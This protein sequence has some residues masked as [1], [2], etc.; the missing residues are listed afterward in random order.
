M[1][2]RILSVVLGLFIVVSILTSCSINDHS[3]IKPTK[4]EQTFA[5]DTLISQD[6]SLGN[7]SDGT[8]RVGFIG[9]S[10]TDGESYTTT[11]GYAFGGKKWIDSICKYLEEKFPNKQIIANN[12]GISG[13]SSD[14]GA[15][16]IEHT[17]YD[18]DPDIVF[19]EYSVNDHMVGFNKELSQKYMEAMVRM[20][21]QKEK[22]PVIIFLYTPYPVEKESLIFTEWQQG[23]YWKQ[24]IADYYG[25]GSINIY[26]YMQTE[27]AKTNY[28]SFSDFLEAESSYKKTDEDEFDV[29]A[30]YEFYSAAIIQSFEE[31]PSDFFV[32]PNIKTEWFEN[33][34]YKNNTYLHYN[35]IEYNS[36]RLIYS[37]N[38][39]LYNLSNITIAPEYFEM[40]GRHDDDY[41]SMQPSKWKNM[42]A[43]TEPG[44]SISFTTDADAV[45]VNS[46]GVDDDFIMTAAVFIDNEYFCSFSSSGYRLIATLDGKIHEIK[47]ITEECN[48]Q[49]CLFLSVNYVEAYMEPKINDN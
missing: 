44:A 7:S 41:P 35:F 43:T 25:I 38:W 5:A 8:L 10:L 22:V 21:Q 31:R 40:S 17:I 49:E 1:N 37:D 2:S 48:K 18:F 45:F 9:G 6:G 27:F 23:V 4:K 14:Y 19:I 39:S 28:S 11:E 16:R 46:Q 13:T 12:S 20:A 24:E 15:M 42:M 36:E 32:H 34:I 29:H 33:G 3:D 47:I 26:D 30:G